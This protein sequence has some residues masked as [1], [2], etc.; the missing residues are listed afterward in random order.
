MKKSLLIL[1]FFSLLL[2]FKASAQGDQLIKRGEY[3]LKFLDNSSLIS[4]ELAQNLANTFF[5]VYPKM[6]KDLNPKATK[7]VTLMLDTNYKKVAVSGKG[8]ILIGALW[9]SQH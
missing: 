8:N 2:S 9:M 7:T 4:E 6:V 5:E 3:T 1:S